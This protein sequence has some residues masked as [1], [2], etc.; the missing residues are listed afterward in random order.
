MM[1]MKVPAV[2]S[3]ISTKASVMARLRFTTSGLAAGAG[4]VS[5]NKRD[6]M[7]GPDPAAPIP[8]KA[9]LKNL[10]LLISISSVHLRYCR[11]YRPPCHYQ[12]L[13]GRIFFK[14][15]Y[16]CQQAV[17]SYGRDRRYDDHNRDIVHGLSG[18]KH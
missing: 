12:P 7:P 18:S 17:I 11:C 10:R 6:I 9:Y 5:C 13:G 14:L 2:W 3:P 8:N 4:M 15:P 1:L 16:A